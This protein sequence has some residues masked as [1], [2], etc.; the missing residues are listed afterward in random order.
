MFSLVIKLIT[1]FYIA[2]L[3]IFNIN[4]IVEGNYEKLDITAYIN[5]PT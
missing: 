1:K 4:F 2:N 5:Y 3:P